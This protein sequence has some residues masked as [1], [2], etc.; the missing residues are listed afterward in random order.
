MYVLV[1]GAV[2]FSL[3]ARLTSWFYDQSFS[4]D[5][6]PVFFT[7]PLTAP[8][9]FKLISSKVF[10]HLPNCPAHFFLP[11][12]RVLIPHVRFVRAPLLT[13]LTGFMLTF[14]FFLSPMQL[15]RSYIVASP[16][17]GPLLGRGFRRK[18]P[19]LFLGFLHFDFCPLSSP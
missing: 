17:H 5:V 7:L 15:T 4:D 18:T 11:L 13:D 19:T 8:Y 16:H 14:S 2:F 6:F 3:L 9:F 1:K 12:H 10:V